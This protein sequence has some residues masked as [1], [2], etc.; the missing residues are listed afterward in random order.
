MLPTADLAVARSRVASLGF[1]VAPDGLHPFGTEN[2]CVFFADGTY[3]EPL[4]VA[5]PVKAG[6]ASTRGNVFT[7]RDNAFRYRLGDEG[8]S[9][10][11]FGTGNAGVDHR[12]FTRAGVSAGRILNFSR[13]FIDASGRSDT[14][15]FKLAFA[16]D[17]RAPD[18]FFFTCER[19][20]APDVDR[21]ALQKHNNGVKRIKA[22]VLDAPDP[23]DFAAF[24]QHVVGALPEETSGG[25]R[26]AAANGEVLVRRT[27][28]T[29]GL[30]RPGL[31]LVE[32]VF[33][34]ETLASA[35]TALAAAAIPYT[36]RDG[37][38]TVA[39]AVGQG[40]TFVFEALSSD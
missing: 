24:L 1:T 7:A 20:N 10:L 29:R 39:P 3:L 27:A 6:S 36:A 30:P 15:S 33:G 37:C 14:A 23:C 22:I 9:A 35:E 40:A 13:P 31:R 26:F 4:A 2:C 38:L 25:L 28:K 11:V 18:A 8:F 16:A 21:S 17:L 32:I 12:A 19:V 34:V 5:D